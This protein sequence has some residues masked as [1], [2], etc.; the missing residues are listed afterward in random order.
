VVSVRNL[1]TGKSTE[2]TLVGSDEVDPIQGKISSASPVGQ[3]LI[4]K[5][6]GDI[7]EALLPKGSLKLE[8][9]GYR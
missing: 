7:V 3:S 9:L 8:I 2:Y 5:K 4:G 1:A 6:K